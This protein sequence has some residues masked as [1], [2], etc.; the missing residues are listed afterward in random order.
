MGGFDR[1]G[2]HKIYFLCMLFGKGILMKISRY[3]YWSWIV[4]ATACNSEVLPQ[5]PIW[6]IDLKGT[7]EE[8]MRNLKAGMG[9]ERYLF[10]FQKKLHWRHDQGEANIRCRLSPPQFEDKR[11]KSLRYTIS[12]DPKERDPLAFNEASYVRLKEAW[13]NS[14]GSAYEELGEPDRM[15]LKWDLQHDLVLTV[16][17]NKRFNSYLVEYTR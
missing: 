16:T 6:N 17:V 7:E 8:I 11:L 9:V 1:K 4:L 13:V 10:S 12:V 15:V 2:V 5:D 14:F 3:L